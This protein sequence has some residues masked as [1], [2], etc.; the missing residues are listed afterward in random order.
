MNARA[1]SALAAG[2]QALKEQF[3]ILVTCGNEKEQVELSRRFTDEGN[4]S[5]A[6]VA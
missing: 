6:P 4:P 1:V 2:Y 5:K 3:L